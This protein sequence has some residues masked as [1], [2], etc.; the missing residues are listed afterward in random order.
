[1]WSKYHEHILKREETTK[2]TPQEFGGYHEVWIHSYA[3]V[4]VWTR[5]SNNR[6]RACAETLA[7]RL[8]LPLSYV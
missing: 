7:K 1:M 8:N 4:G 5:D 6:Y 3:V 2:M